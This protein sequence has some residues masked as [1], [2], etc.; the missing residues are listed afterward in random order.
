VAVLL[1][2]PGWPTKESVTVTAPNGYKRLTYRGFEAL[3]VEALRELRSEASGR[4]AAL[5][6]ANAEMQTELA[7]QKEL[8]ARLAARVGELITSV[9]RLQKGADDTVATRIIRP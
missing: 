4:I 5:G 6:A 7:T 9:A 8:N 2:E 1:V 3:T